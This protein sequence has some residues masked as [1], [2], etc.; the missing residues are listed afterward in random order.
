MSQRKNKVLFLPCFLDGLSPLSASVRFR[1]LWPT[2]YMIGADAYDGTQ[3]LGDYDGFVFQKFYLSDKARHWSHAFQD[4]G[5]VLA[6][7]LCD[8]DF[9][10]SDAHRERM[11]KVLPRFDF[12]VAPTEPLV[13]WLRQWLPA[14]LIPDRLDL[15]LHAERHVPQDRKPRLVWFGNSGNLVTLEKIWPAACDLDLSLTILSDR[16]VPPWDGRPVKFVEWTLEGAN[17]VIARHDMALNPKL[18]TGHFA[19]KSNNKTVTAWAL[20]V[21]VAETPEQLATLMDFELRKLESAYRLAEVAAHYDVRI[22]AL[23]WAGLFAEWR[24]RRGRG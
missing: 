17:A 1:A 19:F 16:L 6:F 23:E 15:S 8:A 14:F 2:K 13:E 4:A 12:A 21:P 20:G 10:L 22:S 18:D 7:D 3:R 9:L 11:L 24:E 5:A